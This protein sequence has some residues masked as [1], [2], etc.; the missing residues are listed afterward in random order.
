MADNRTE[1]RHYRP[2]PAAAALAD[3]TKGLFRKRGFARREIL[4]Q[5]PVI[6][7]DMVARYTCP[8]RLRFGRDRS[9]G[10]TL[11]VRASA[12]FALELQHLHPVVLARINTFF[13]YQAVDQIAIVQAPLPAPTP[14]E[15]KQFRDIGEQ[16]KLR[17]AAQ[18]GPTR[19][20][21]LA[22]A[23]TT[24]GQTLAAAD[25]NAGEKPS[26]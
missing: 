14:A 5:W 19:H 12:G 11:V 23:L 26:D 13:G 4:T 16:E 22:S 24:L 15:R 6:V 9:E 1:R 18:V 20:E 17:I 10:A 8:E 25:T 2:R 7:G 21:G 3:V